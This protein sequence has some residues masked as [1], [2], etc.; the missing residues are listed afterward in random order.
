MTDKRKQKCHICSH[1]HLF[2]PGKMLYCRVLNYL[3]SNFNAKIQMS[4]FFLQSHHVT[5]L[6][7]QKL[8]QS[9]T[10]Y[11]IKRSRP[12][13][14]QQYLQFVERCFGYWHMH[15][16]RSSKPA[17]DS[18]TS[19]SDPTKEEKKISLAMDCSH[20]KNY[21]SSTLSKRAQKRVNFM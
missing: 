16:N 3:D 9:S 8:W 19:M 11:L 21:D 2:K 7:L 4:F 17:E 1:S 6:S 12:K 15:I 14:S 10:S 20:A 18:Q 5:M 13:D